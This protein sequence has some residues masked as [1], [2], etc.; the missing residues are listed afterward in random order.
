M[1]SPGN[2]GLSLVWKGLWEKIG[3][4]SELEDKL[5]EELTRFSSV[6]KEMSAELDK[7]V[8]L[9][10][11]VLFGDGTSRGVVEYLD[12][13]IAPEF[14]QRRKL[15][16]LVTSPYKLVAGDLLEMRFRKIEDIINAG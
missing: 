2:I 13:D 12:K 4:M 8:S 6:K 1:G 3:G 14:D 15:Y 9:L 11:E 7:K 16:K 10:Q 5:K